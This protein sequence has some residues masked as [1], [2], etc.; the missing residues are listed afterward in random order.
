[1]RRII[2]SKLA[3]FGDPTFDR[4]QH[5]YDRMEPSYEEFAEEYYVYG[6]KGGHGNDRLVPDPFPSVESAKRYVEDSVEDIRYLGFDEVEIRDQHNEFI[7]SL[8]LA[9][10]ESEE[11]NELGGF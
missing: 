2:S 6:T 8:N 11:M 1:M 7:T 10:L 4:A 5:D 3:Q 9:E